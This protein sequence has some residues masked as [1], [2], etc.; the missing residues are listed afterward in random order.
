VSS[1]KGTSVADA[2]DQPDTCKGKEEGRVQEPAKASGRDTPERRGQGRKRQ[3][4]Q[5]RAST[6]RRRDSRRKE[7]VQLDD[8][9]RLQVQTRMSSAR[10]SLGRLN[11]ALTLIRYSMFRCGGTLHG[12]YGSPVQPQVRRCR[13]RRTQPRPRRMYTAYTSTAK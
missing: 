8:R 6:S 11:D 9:V 3:P 12:D 5:G 4:C 1:R 13:Q 2:R 10:Q 7:L